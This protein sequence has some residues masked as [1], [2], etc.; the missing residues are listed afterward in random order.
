MVAHLG[1]VDATLH[2]LILIN[3]ALAR[4]R[5]MSFIDGAGADANDGD[6]HTL[7]DRYTLPHRSR[8]A[9]IRNS[10]GWQL[11]GR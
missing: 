2:E 10:L 4:F 7:H 11:S 8:D 3:E 5:L 6:R 9:A 1:R